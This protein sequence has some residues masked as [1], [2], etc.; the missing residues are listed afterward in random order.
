MSDHEEGVTV[1]VS[2]GMRD[3]GL[4]RVADV[5]EHLVPIERDGL[6][7]RRERPR[8]DD[9]V[10]EPP[11]FGAPL[12][13]G[14]CLGVRESEFES[15]DALGGGNEHSTVDGGEIDLVCSVRN[16]R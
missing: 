1:L 7:P 6:L 2:P 14:E 12:S 10:L 13:A 8:H 4:R 3:L 5:E 9:L 16:L 11:A 15:N